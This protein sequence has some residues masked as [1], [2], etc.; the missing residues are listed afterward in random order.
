MQLRW[1]E[2]YRRLS[3]LSKEAE[4]E[5]QVAR[6]NFVEAQS[7]REYMAQ[8]DLVQE[9]RDIYNEVR[10]L[11]EKKKKMEETLDRCRNEYRNKNQELLRLEK[12]KDE[13]EQNLSRL[14]ENWER[15][16]GDRQRAF[17]L[18]TQSAVSKE[19]LDYAAKVHDRN[20]E[21]LGR[22]ISQKNKIYESIEK[23]RSKEAEIIKQNY[24][25]WMNIRN[26]E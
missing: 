25:E 11:L 2:E 21:D 22:E 24:S 8:Y 10:S 20:K 15:Q 23:N 3:G 18:D 14:K 12:I 7:R 26:E 1:I 5:W 17:A 16:A 6:K 13:A 4:T 19:A 9:V